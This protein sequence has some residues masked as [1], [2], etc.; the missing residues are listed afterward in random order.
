MNSNLLD[1]PTGDDLLDDLLAESMA[2]SAETGR[3]KAARRKL[4]D[5]RI[6]LS[7]AEKNELR[8]IV[9][10]YDEKVLW[11]TVANVAL[12]HTQECVTCGTHSEFFM[13]WMREQHHR[14]MPNTRRLV[15]GKSPSRIPSRVERHKQHDVECCPA[16]V[17][18][19]VLID[20]AIRSAEC[21]SLSQQP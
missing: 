5:E 12:L 14:T 4:A 11:D 10:A 20:E 16:C 9:D 3:V 21:A 7:L 1:D 17:E 19:S 13:G 6:A 8:A 2:I 15:A 18:A